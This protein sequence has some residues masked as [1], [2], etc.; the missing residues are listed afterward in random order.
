M[1][2]PDRLAELDFFRG[3]PDR[4]LARLAE[5]AEI[6][7][8]GNSELVVHQHDRAIAVYFL[9]SGTIQ[10]LI[11]VHGSDEDLLVGV[12]RRPGTL[13]GW[14][15]FRA[16]YRYTTS[17][18]CEQ[19]CRLVR[20]PHDTFD[21]LLADDPEAAVEVLHRVGAALADRLEQ[22]RERLIT[23]S[24]KGGAVEPARDEAPHP[25]HASARPAQPQ[26]DNPET[27][28][29]FLRETA[30]FERASGTD[31]EHLAGAAH[32][33]RFAPGEALFERGAPATDMFLL[34]QG[35][36]GLAYGE[37]DEHD[38][39][40]LRSI[41]WHG[42][43]LGWSAMVPPY[44]YHLTAV[45]TEPTDAVALSRD[46]LEARCR[47]APE[48]G[49]VFL[50]QI[51]QLIGYRLGATRV[52]LVAR[53]YNE[54]AVAIRAILDHA[55]ET[56]KVTS[57]L[58]KLPYLLEN[59][60]TLA[61]AI[62]MLE[63]TQA[64]GDE[65]EVGLAALCLDI[66]REVQ[67]EIAIY[68]GLQRAYEVVANAPPDRSPQEVRTACMD[69]FARFFAGI[70]YVI[71][72]T[73]RLP[74]APGHIVIMNHLENH[75]DNLLPNDFRLTLDT[76]FVSSMILYPRYGEAPIRVIRKPRSDW[77]GFQEYFDR[78]DYIYV[79]PGEVDEEDRD[80]NLTRADRQRQFMDRARAHLLAGRNVVIA[81]EG[82]CYHTE[83]SPGP[84]RRGAFRLAAYVQ[85]EP[86]IVPVA[87]ANF[88]KK[89]SRTVVAAVVQEPFRLS[90]KVP[91]P[92]DDDALAA[93]VKAYG[94]GFRPYV[95]EAIGLAEGAAR[96][97]RP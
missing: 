16:P 49:L 11:R 67:R 35:R 50:R 8:H 7:E 73:E 57:P 95:E 86:L 20:I 39:T 46:A 76:H 36:V 84:F 72:G 75:P 54:E 30:L 90:E 48:F 29:G 26:P 94:E 91:D 62:H 64:H 28:V 32:L 81:P 55:A 63:L 24:R 58:H 96:V 97:R 19:R 38:T 80:R 59:R 47:E 27:V 82:A 3:L 77:Y 6:R 41:G 83:E 12:S 33:V 68:R 17:A 34:L 85:P 56:L 43:P 65:A 66:L 79:Y 37:P 18:R 74:D 89:L 45:A 71:A 2:P 13:I 4:V 78:L 22:E 14:S 44:R 93:F 69:E 31:L 92:D 52:R 53:R 51:L 10:F 40:F 70:R 61:D 60:L 87:V 1:I 42:A 88:D 25:S 23:A 15:V 5:A 21:A 9:L